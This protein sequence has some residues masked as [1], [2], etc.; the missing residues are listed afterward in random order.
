MA[1]QRTAGTSRGTGR[2]SCGHPIHQPALR[3]LL[4]WGGY[5]PYPEV[6]CA[7]CGDFGT[8]EKLSPSSSASASSSD[9]LELHGQAK[10]ETK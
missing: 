6:Q 4:A 9:T 2:L 3:L 5:R 1:R 10:G 7:V 8:V